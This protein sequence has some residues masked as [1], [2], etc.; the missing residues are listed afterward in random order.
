M[1]ARGGIRLGIG[2]ALCVVGFV[3]AKGTAAYRETTVTFDAD[4]CHLVTDIIDK[5]EDETQGSVVLLH[6]LSANK[7]IMEHLARAFAEQNLRVFVPDLPGH[8]RT[9]GT[10]TFA[11]AEGCGESLVRE[12]IARKVIDPQRTIL[13]GHSMGGAIAIRLAARV[14]VAGVIAISPAPMRVAHGVPGDMLP[15]SNPPPVPPHTLA[16]SAALEPLG[17]RELTRELVAGDATATSQYLFVPGATHVSVL[18]DGRVVRA[19]Q[20][21]AAKTLDSQ[22]R[23]SVPSSV[24]LIGGTLGL[25]G[26]LLLA[27][28]FLR[29]TIGA[30]NR[31]T[32]NVAAES[33]RLGDAGAS[34]PL[35]RSSMEVALAS[36]FAVVVLRYW[37]PLDFVGMYNGGYFASFMLITGLALLALHRKAIR[38]L[39]ITTRTT[40]LLRAGFAALVLHLLVTGWLDATFIE[41]WA[42]AGRWARFPVFFLAAL[43]YLLAEELL[44]GPGGTRKAWMRLLAAMAW[45]LV[46][47][48][49]IVL[50]IFVLHSGALLLILLSVFL[51]MFFVFQ[52]MGMDLVRRET[53]SLLAAAVFG[54]I[55]L[56]GFCLVIFPVT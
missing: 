47:F 5:G 32:A 56:A 23:G 15:Y 37:N 20:D 29:E 46:A 39:V 9:Q 44:L 21:W 53:G 55:L 13:A 27:G 36:L 45:R 7:K 18:F 19:A 31:E 24:P 10:F 12:L 42:S 8:G 41:A 3:L 54:A 16:I 6:G 49:A 40:T 14:G 43:S 52:R 1:K 11:R 17:I 26:I 22:A 28:P 50:G 48:L 33:K 51:A 2:V 4:G 34:L 35:L 38:T 25:A 30:R